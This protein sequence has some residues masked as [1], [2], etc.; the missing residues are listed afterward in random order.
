MISNSIYN[1][2]FHTKQSDD[3]LNSKKEYRIQQIQQIRNDS[4]KNENAMLQYNK[5]FYGVE[6]TPS[7]NDFQCSSDQKVSTL[8]SFRI[9]FVIAVFLLTFLVLMDITQKPFG[10]ITIETIK[11]SISMDYESLIVSRLQN[12][13]LSVLGN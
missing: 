5:F 7:E 9:R 3:E 10:N 12:S 4:Q 13:I 8:F 1:D 11:A 2:F 6:N